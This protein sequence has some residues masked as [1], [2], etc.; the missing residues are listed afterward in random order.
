[1]P[2]PLVST[3]LVR[4][5]ADAM[6]KVGKTEKTAVLN[7]LT[8]MERRCTSGTV[9][10]L[11]DTGPIERHQVQ[12]KLNRQ[13]MLN[14]HKKLGIIC[15]QGVTAINCNQLQLKIRDGDLLLH[16]GWTQL[17]PHHV[18]GQIL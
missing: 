11:T 14:R 9:A 7:S 12:Q 5:I 1:M 16:C 3:V 10:K 13:Q 2:K 6:N 4:K 17:L 15:C 8:D 18:S